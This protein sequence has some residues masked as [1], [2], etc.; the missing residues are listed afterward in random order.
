MEILNLFRLRNSA[1][2]GLALYCMRMAAG[3][4]DTNTFS[5]AGPGV[6]LTFRH[7]NERLALTQMQR[8]EDAPML[9]ADRNAEQSGAG[10][11][12]NPLAV[13]IR[14]GKFKGN[15]GMDS[16]RV[17]KLDRT[18]NTLRVFLE[19]A[20]I[21]LQ[22]GLNVSVDGSVVNWLGQ[23]VWNGEEGVE[24]EVYYPLL[25][26][27]R[28]ASPASD[29]GI[30][31]QIS[32]SVREPL[33]EINYAQNYVGR[34]SSPVF[35]V[36]GGGR[37]LAWLDDNRADYG[38][39]PSAVSLRSY[40]VGNRFP[41]SRS[42]GKTG[43]DG[44]FVGVGHTRVFQPISAFGGEETYNSAE[45]PREPLPLRKLGD[46]VDLGP[47]RTFAYAGTWKAG[48]S[49]LREQ[50]AWFPMRV[51]PAKWY[52]RTTF[53][54]EEG[55]GSLARRNGFD[56]L[57]EILEQKRKLGADLF[58]ITGF[59][60]P[61]ILGASGQS[62][63]DYFLSSQSLGGPDALRR[64]IEATHRAG[65]HVAFYIEGLIVWK[66]SRI[67]RSDAQAWAL[68]EPDGK[69]TEHYKGF[70][71]AC[72]A[73][74]EYQEWFANMCAEIVRATGV[75]GFFIDSELATY[76]HRCFNPSHHHP[77]PDV[78]TW[79][80]RQLLKRTREAVDKVNPD[81]L[82][83]AEGCGDIGREFG[84]G[85]IAHTHMWSQNTFSE[86][87]VRFLHAD[88]RAYESWGS[89]GREQT[90][91]SERLHVFNAVNGHRIYAHNAV[92]DRMALLSAQTRRYYD[93]FPEICDS[94]MSALDVKA[95]NCIAQLF[96]GPPRV[97]T[98]GNVTD[99][100]VEGK[101]TV[102]IEATALYDR[103]EGQRIGLQQKQA[104]VKLKPWE[105]RAFEVRP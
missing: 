26:R 9:Y 101:L 85:F 102:P 3:A 53:L 62:R 57:P 31:P 90:Q 86:P 75:D 35:L 94:P 74:R 64:G 28:F 67:G 99:Q 20:S 51:S 8:G 103:V 32:G 23:A 30:F 39:D 66:R 76:N 47:V 71:H 55:A 15:Y 56:G 60:D 1:R 2:L 5:V 61:E 10:P 41:P 22:V 50:R 11:V 54:A 79:G 104:T 95:E 84:D 82:L 7:E 65:G 70:W 58:F 87:L 78:W 68:M 63:G 13:V 6:T 21:P 83:F 48:A 36:E 89:G 18:E 59:S 25:S 33:G 88:M 38:P 4:A 98:I 100:V 40:A 37:G 97:V 72:P 14:D 43:G 19:H 93:S 16:F 77:Q 29:R 24:A 73:S 17:L 69:Y 45:R 96:E 92:R 81:T 34:F 42:A 46:A 91:P 44:P 52:Q 49:W 105:F 27:V 12:G 80:I